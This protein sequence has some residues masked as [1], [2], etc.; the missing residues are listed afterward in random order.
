[1]PHLIV[2]HSNNLRENIDHSILLEGLHQIMTLVTG[3]NSVKSRLVCH[4]QFRVGTGE[5]NR[6]FIHVTILLLAG[7][8]NVLKK[9]LGERVLNFLKEEF[10][11]SFQLLSCDFSVAFEDMNSE[12]YF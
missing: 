11:L 6:A 5:G 3:S 1:M 4:E 7:R 9:E 12:G 2:E 10:A 8:D